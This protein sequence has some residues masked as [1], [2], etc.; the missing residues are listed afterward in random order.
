MYTGRSDI[1]RIRRYISLW[2]KEYTTYN[3][4]W[5]DGNESHWE[6]LNPYAQRVAISGTDGGQTAPFQKP[7]E[8][9][10]IYINSLFKGGT[11]KQVGSEKYLGFDT[12]RYEM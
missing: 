9:I 5:F 8:T 4:T 12:Y 7:R 3:K 2:D 10:E 6:F 11:G 1:T